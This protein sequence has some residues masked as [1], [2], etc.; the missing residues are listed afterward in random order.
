MGMMIIAGTGAKEAERVLRGGK[1]VAPMCASRGQEARR[2]GGRRRNWG[3]GMAKRRPTAQ[4]REMDDGIHAVEDVSCTMVAKSTRL[5]VALSKAMLHLASGRCGAVTVTSRELGA[6][7][8]FSGFQ[9]LSVE[10]R[11]HFSAIQWSAG[12]IGPL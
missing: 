3:L 8:R 2:R 12:A 9:W 10:C 4:L 7:C 11:W 1:R 6:A 5:L